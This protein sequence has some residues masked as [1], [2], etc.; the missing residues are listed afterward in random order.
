MA[1]PRELLKKKSMAKTKWYELDNAA[2]IVPS[3]T[4][5]ADTRVF[6]I[7]CELKEEV[8]GTLLQQALD[9]TVPDFPHF[10]SILRK[11]LFWYYLDSSDIRAVVQ[12]ENK[13][14][15]AIYREGRRRLLY[16]VN[17]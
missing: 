15:S 3:T 10:A 17:Y 8:D 11:G 16:R 1:S 6:R 5:G 14:C 4:K 9:M 7:S 13:P 12:P 2:K